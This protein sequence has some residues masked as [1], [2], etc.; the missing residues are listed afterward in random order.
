MTSLIRFFLGLPPREQDIKELFEMFPELYDNENIHFREF[1]HILDYRLHHLFYEF[2]ESLFDNLKKWMQT[3]NENINVDFTYKNT[4]ICLE[5]NCPLKNIQK[6]TKIDTNSDLDS[7]CTLEY[8]VTGGGPNQKP[9]KNMFFELVK[10]SKKKLKE[11]KEVILTDPYIY[12][13]LSEDGI[14]GGLNTLIEYLYTLGFTKDSHFIL[15]ITPSPKGTSNKTRVIFENTLKKT[16]QNIKID[17]FLPKYKFH[18]R[19]YIIKDS[20]GQINGLFGP[21]LNGLNSSSIVLMGEIEGES[22]I[23]KLKEW[24]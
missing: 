18:D 23:K 11:I 21:S 2:D 8:M 7:N 3:Q 1:H 15:K 20:K 22:S 17:K 5:K 9:P 10:K 24:F 19:F 12:H 4:S 6:Q 13:D 16:F 14:E